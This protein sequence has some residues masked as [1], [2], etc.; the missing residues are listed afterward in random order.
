MYVE[1]EVPGFKEP[2][3]FIST[4]LDWHEDPKVRLEQIRAINGKAI[5]LRGIKI[6]LGDLNDTKESLVI[7]ELKRYWD[8]PLLTEKL[9]I[10]LGLQI[11][12]KLALTIYLCLKHKNGI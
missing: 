7:Q 8:S 3:L 6:L 2:I 9:I 11:T 4:H 1:S 10:E 12:L 5:D